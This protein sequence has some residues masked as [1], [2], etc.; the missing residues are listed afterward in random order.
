MGLRRLRRSSS[1]KPGAAKGRKA[2]RL[3]AAAK[4]HV[5]PSTED[6]LAER[7]RRMELPKP[8]P[9]V[10]E[11]SLERYK[12]WLNTQQGRNRWRD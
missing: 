4:D 8:P 12:E 3:D 5:H 10:R 7:L 2:E 9:G 6:R 11:R 1:A